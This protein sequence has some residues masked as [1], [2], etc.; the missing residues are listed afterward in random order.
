MRDLRVLMVLV[1]LHGANA[2]APARSIRS[3]VTMRT[4]EVSKAQA[5]KVIDNACRKLKGDGGVKKAIGEFAGFTNI[6]GFGSPREGVVQVR[7]NA[8]FKKKG[9]TFKTTTGE[10][11]KANRG[12]M[13]GQVK[14][15]ADLNSGKLMELAVF[16]DLGY[17]SSVN[18][19]GP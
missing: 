17:G 18:V 6:L 19:R 4:T 12:A 7:F 16:K 9:G 5:M 13:V 1:A 2:F 3:T 14:A 11:K 10:I 8:Q 15:A